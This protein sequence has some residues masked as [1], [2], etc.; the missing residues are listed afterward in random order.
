MS[1][2]GAPLLVTG[3]HR[4]GTTWVGAMLCLSG[5]AVSLHEPTNPGNRHAWL[6]HLVDGPYRA[7]GPDSGAA[8]DTATRRMLEFRPPRRA[9]ISTARSPREVAASLREIGRAELWRA[10]RP[11]LIIK[12]PLAAFSTEWW[13]DA[14]GIEPLILIRH[15]AAFAGSL[16]KLGWQ[17]DFV[18]LANQPHLLSGPLASMASEIEAA[19]R[20]QPDLIGQATLLWRAVNRSLVELADRRGWAVHRYEDLASEPLGAFHRLY[21][22]YGLRWDGSVE[23]AIRSYTSSE[24]AGEVSVADRLSIRRDSSTAMTTWTKRLDGA[25]IDRVRR[26]TAEI[27]TRFYTESDWALPA[28]ETVDE[29]EV[30]Q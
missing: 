22:Q 2:S 25:E 24:N 28:P 30:A 20:T 15:P 13:H 17:F 29:D 10:R 1:G 23:A 4:S 21:D 9:L 27:S 12:D 6:R 14:Y 3:T 18:H 11:R 7:L 8:L 16:K 26:E 5:E 19:A